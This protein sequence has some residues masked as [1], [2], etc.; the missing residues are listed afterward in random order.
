MG[1]IP[2]SFIKPSAGKLRRLKTLSGATA[3]ASSVAPAHSCLTLS[4]TLAW[5][6]LC[7][8]MLALRSWSKFLFDSLDVT[9]M[10]TAA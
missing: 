4:C 9:S 3:S 5:P 6:L 2:H 7:D 8:H 1:G 10:A